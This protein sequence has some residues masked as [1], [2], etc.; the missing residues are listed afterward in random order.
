[1]CDCQKTKPTP[2]P[3]AVLDRK[4]ETVKIAPR[5]FLHK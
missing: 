3:V 4:G 1:M 5:V 2:K